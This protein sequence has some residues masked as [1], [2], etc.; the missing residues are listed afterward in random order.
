MKGGGFLKAVIRDHI[1][2]FFRVY[3]PWLVLVG[4]GGGAF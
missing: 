3:K 1:L 4:V 2:F